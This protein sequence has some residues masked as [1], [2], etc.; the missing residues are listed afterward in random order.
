MTKFAARVDLPSPGVFDA[1]APYS[2]EHQVETAKA[3]KRKVFQERV[4]LLNTYWQIKIKQILHEDFYHRVQE[5]R[6]RLAELRKQI[7]QTSK[8]IT[9]LN[10]VIVELENSSLIERMKKGFSKNDLEHAHE[11]LTRQQQNHKRLLSIQQ[12]I[13]NEITK[14]ELDAPITPREQ[15]EFRETSK[16]ID[17]LGG[18]EKVTKAVEDFISVDEQA[19]LR[20]KLFIATG[21]SAALIDPAIRNQQFDLV[22]VDEAQRVNLPTLAAL[23][24]LAKEKFVIAGDPFQVEP[25]SISRG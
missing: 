15:M 9:Q 4:G 19:L 24:T 11:Q 18:L 13:S 7:D 25:E 14:I 3:E 12:T 16:R 10:Q 6:D 5:K 22:I 8:E 17:D 20:S 23:S 21:I 1:I 2:F